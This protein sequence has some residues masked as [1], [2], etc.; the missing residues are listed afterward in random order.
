[1]LVE[2][3]QDLLEAFQPRLVLDCFCNAEFKAVCD[4]VAGDQV[5]DLSAKLRRNSVVLPEVYA[6]TICKQVDDL[7]VPIFD[8]GQFEH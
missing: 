4:T 6:R 3:H 5:I 8:A 7:V 1:M 2:E